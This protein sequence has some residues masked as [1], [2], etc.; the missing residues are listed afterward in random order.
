M[1]GKNYSKYQKDLIKRY[2]DNIED[3][4]TQ[5]LGEI[6]SDLYL[7]TKSLRKLQL[8]KS[9]ETA[10][11]HL[12]GPKE[13]ATIDAVIASKDVKQLAKLVEKHF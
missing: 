8:W 3:I 2:Y 7:E 6:V 10:L 11:N 1:A 4:S 13:K 9:A 12:L 5:K